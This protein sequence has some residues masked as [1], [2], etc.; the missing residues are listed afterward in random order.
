MQGPRM[1]GCQWAPGRHLGGHHTHYRHKILMVLQGP[2]MRECRWE[3]SASAGRPALL[4]APRPTC[5]STA[6]S[7]AD[8]SPPGRCFPCP[9]SAPGIPFHLR[10][11]A[12]CCAAAALVAQDQK[13]H[14]DLRAQCSSSHFLLADTSCIRHH[15]IV[16]SMTSTRILHSRIHSG[17]LRPEKATL[18]CAGGAG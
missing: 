8:S 9:D 18:S 11:V 7:S 5:P 13:K 16:S 2:W 17:C 4:S 15:G 14:M 1:Q 3:A 12:P 10:L 6:Q